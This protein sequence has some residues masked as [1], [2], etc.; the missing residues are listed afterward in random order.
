MQD[1]SAFRRLVLGISTST[2]QP[3]SSIAVSTLP[4]TATDAHNPLGLAS[5]GPVEFLQ[6]IVNAPVHQ[7]QPPFV[8]RAVPPVHNVPLTIGNA[9][10][11]LHPSATA[12]MQ[13]H[14]T[15][16][17]PLHTTGMQP[18]HTTGMQP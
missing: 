7:P 16:M 9:M 8:T 4:P 5:R 13:P 18:L 14:T 10:H 17:Q 1:D 2:T 3:N 15:G 6:S 11:Q 12:G